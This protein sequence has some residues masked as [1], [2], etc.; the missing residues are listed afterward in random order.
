AGLAIPVFFTF[1]ILFLKYGVNIINHLIIFNALPLSISH[2]FNVFSSI[3]QRHAFLF[4]FLVIFTG[5]VRDKKD[6]LYWYC[7]LSPITLLFSAKIGSETNYFLEIIAL[8]SVAT[9]ILFEKIEVSAK[10]IFLVAC[11]AQMF[12]FLPFKSAPVFTKTYGQELPFA[13][14]SHPSVALKEAGEIIEGELMSVS[15]PVFS[16]DTGWLVVAGKQ[17]IMEPYQFSQLA[18]YGRW[19]DDHIV[20]MIKEKQFNLILM[21]AVSYEK[22]S[23]KFTLSM[24]E[25]IRANYQIKRVIGNLYILEPKLWAEIW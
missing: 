24:L 10:G 17:V 21:N 8:S 9:G 19:D 11:I 25:A 12:L 13:T 4:S 15:D 18:R 2:F 5:M 3:G 20:D 14:G 23:E 7:L 1:F 22:G 16:E 6:P